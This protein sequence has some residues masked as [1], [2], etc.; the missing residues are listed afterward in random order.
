MLLRRVCQKLKVKIFFDI[1]TSLIKIL[2]AKSLKF[3]I[4]TIA[5]LQFNVWCG[6]ATEKQLRHLLA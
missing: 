5:Y 6:K 3:K 4:S 1:R 2:L